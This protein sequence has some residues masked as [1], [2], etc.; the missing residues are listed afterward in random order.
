MAIDSALA[1]VEAGRIRL[2]PAH[3]RDAHYPGSARLGHGTY[4]LRARGAARGRGAQ[5]PPDELAG[6][7]YYVPTDHGAE[8]ALA[9]RGWPE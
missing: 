4:V 9:T 2:V 1:D 3:L 6:A 8:A 7:R 5:Y